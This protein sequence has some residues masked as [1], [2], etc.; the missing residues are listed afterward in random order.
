MDSSGLVPRVAKHLD[1]LKKK[2]NHYVITSSIEFLHMETDNHN[3]SWTLNIQTQKYTYF[4]WQISG[5]AC[6]HAIGVIMP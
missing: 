3:Q 6:V 1:D 5:I 2:Y 4:E